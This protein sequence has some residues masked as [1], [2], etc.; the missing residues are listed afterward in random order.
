MKINFQI[1]P[2]ILAYKKQ[3]QF[4]T[5]KKRYTAVEATTK[6]GKTVG[7]IVWIYGEACKGTHGDH[8]WWIA[9]I[10]AQSKI[11][12]RRL[13]RFIRPRSLFR[14][15]NSELTIKLANGATI[16]F[17]S[18]DNPDALYG[19]DVKAVVID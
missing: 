16:W 7:C 3:M 13:K 19:E 18:S 9:P 8:Y 14:A 12:F 17:K 2:K 4:I 11:A 15:N 6:A 10:N 1:P 5:T